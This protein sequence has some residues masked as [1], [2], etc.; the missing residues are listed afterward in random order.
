M[1][2]SRTDLPITVMFQE[3]NT[4]DGVIRVEILTA[5]YTK[6]QLEVLQ[7]QMIQHVQLLATSAL[8][9]HGTSRLDDVSDGCTRLLVS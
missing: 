5:K 3:G 1:E 7:S 4:C 9:C 2:T 6:T 8:M